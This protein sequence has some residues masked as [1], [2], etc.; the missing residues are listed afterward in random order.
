VCEYWVI[1]AVTL[2]TMVHRKPSGKV[3]DAVE[4]VAPGDTL[5]PLQVRAFAVSLGALD[6]H[7][8]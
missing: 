5:V 7:Q 6:L 2:T 8:D 1:N 4:E 3:Y